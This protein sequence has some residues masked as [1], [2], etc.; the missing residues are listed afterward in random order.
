ML[1]RLAPFL[2][3]LAFWTLVFML[4]AHH[5]RAHD[6]WA[7]GTAVPAWVKS[8]CCGP[9]DAHMLDP[10]Q[11]SQ[12]QCGDNKQCWKV[13]GFPDLV[14]DD[15]ALPSQD[16]HFWAFYHTYESYISSMYCFFVPMSF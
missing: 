7:D 15:Q 12:V 8:A 6:Q 10:S 1:Y 2:F 11:V 13:E 14:P 5:A 3:V 9:N 4:L 16:G